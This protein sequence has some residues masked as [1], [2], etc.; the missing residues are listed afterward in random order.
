MFPMACQSASNVRAL[1]FLKCAFSLE[2]TISIGMMSIVDYLVVE[3]ADFSRDLS[4]SDDRA[5]LF[6]PS[7]PAYCG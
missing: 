1:A 4:Q 5:F 6:Y 3:G 2:N 7:G